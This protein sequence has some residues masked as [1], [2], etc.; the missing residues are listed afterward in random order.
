M[1]SACAFRAEMALGGVPS[2]GR[3]VLL[4]RLAGRIVAAEVWRPAGSLP[5]VGV[6]LVAAG[7]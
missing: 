1:A 5:R 2:C 4:S 3:P 7:T 6:L